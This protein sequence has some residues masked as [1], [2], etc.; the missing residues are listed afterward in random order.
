[1]LWDGLTRILARRQRSE[2]ARCVAAAA[3]AIS[4]SN[5][6]LAKLVD[7][8]GSAGA[9][10]RPNVVAGLD[11]L[12]APRELPAAV[13]SVFD[14]AGPLLERLVP[15]NPEHLGAYAV[16]ADEHPL[17]PMVKQVAQWYGLRDFAVYSSRA[18]GLTCQPFGAAHAAIVVGQG[19]LHG[20]AGAA[21]QRFLI[22]RALKLAA[23]GMAYLVHTDSLRLEKAL[24]DL[25][26]HFVPRFRSG[27]GC[28]ALNK[29]LE[30]SMSAETCEAL[31]ADLGRLLDAGFDPERLSAAAWRLADRS[32]LAMT[33]DCRAGLAALL[34]LH[35][36]SLSP[37][38]SECVRAVR[39]VPE[40]ADLLAFAVSPPYLQVR[41][42]AQ[43]R[44]EAD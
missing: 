14:L 42:Q 38:A 23:S 12:L 37:R 16:T 17:G 15:T 10:E 35:S 8:R 7:R 34:R 36:R 44:S 4:V 22:A 19:L 43:R 11:E 32:A 1:M 18:P 27:A 40:A 26:E 28:A 21:E 9:A 33:G 25:L 39:A 5:A 30:T 2:A 6:A 41:E 13:R 29:A 24:R 31:A 3:A 20:G